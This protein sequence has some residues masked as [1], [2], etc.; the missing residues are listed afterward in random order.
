MAYRIQY[1]Q[2]KA[3]AAGKMDKRGWAAFAMVALL[4]AGAITV[5]VVGLTWVQEV[6]LPGDPAVTAAALEGVVEDL[7]AGEGL[8]AALTD[9]CRYIMDH[10]A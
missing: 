7:K 3:P 2:V 1:D 8:L 5:K 10:G 6:L 4:L 9:F